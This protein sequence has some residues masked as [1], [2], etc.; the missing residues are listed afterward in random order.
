MAETTSTEQPVAEEPTEAAP[1]AEAKAS[2][3]KT[4]LGMEE[5]VEALLCYLAGWIT[6]LV[7]FLLEKESKFVKFHAMQSIVTFLV[8]TLLGFFAGAIP[9]IGWMIAILIWPLNLILWILLMVKAYQGEK[10][11]LPVIGDFAEKQAG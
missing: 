1:A 10:F 2:G 5:N 7:F 6:G 9:F 3:K 11:K 4:S 8:L